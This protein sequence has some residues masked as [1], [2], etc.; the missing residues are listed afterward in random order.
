MICNLNYV[1]ILVATLAYFIIG[2]LWY[3]LLFGKVW[4]Q[5]LGIV[6]TE[7]DKKKMPMMFSVTFALNFIIVVAT[8]CVLFFVSPTT[9]MAAVKVGLLLGGGFV[10]TTIAMSYMY[11]RRSFKLTL[12]DTGYHVFAICVTSVILTLWH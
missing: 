9:V 1:H 6:P 5:M 10:F 12:I 2:S 4:S 8:A 3:S 7:E 11:S